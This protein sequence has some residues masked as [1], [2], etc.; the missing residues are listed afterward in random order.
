MS[1][2]AAPSQ[3]PAHQKKSHRK[4]KDKS[5]KHRSKKR[6]HDDEQP[7]TEF[8]TTD[9]TPFHIQTTSLY[10][11]LTPIAQSDPIA[12]LCAEH[13]SPLILTYYPPLSGVLLSYANIRLSE[14]PFPRTN[15]DPSLPILAKAIDE[16]AATFIWLTADF[17]ILRPE[18]GVWIEGWVNLHNESH[19]GLIYL[20]FISASI[21]CAQLPASWKWVSGRSRKGKKVPDDGEGEGYWVDGS[22]EK[23]E[24]MIRFRIKESNMQAKTDEERG[25]IT[26]TGTLLDDE[27]R[28]S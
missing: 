22:G 16:Y 23:V 18:K 20:N 24:G 10:L 21:P 5:E 3:A 13:L 15:R 11:P 4:H 17:L 27:E 2:E 25:F 19:L 6:R 8:S 28:E 1:A 14:T 26:I 9:E 7:T 12:G